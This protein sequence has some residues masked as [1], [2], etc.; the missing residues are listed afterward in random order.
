VLINMYIFLI[1]NY[2]VF[3]MI[4]EFMH[5]VVIVSGILK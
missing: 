2:K 5:F 1:Q 4:E 3:D